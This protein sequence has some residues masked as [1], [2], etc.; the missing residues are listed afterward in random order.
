MDLW[1]NDVELRFFNE[2]L[3]SFAAPEKLFYKLGKEYYAYV[4]KNVGGDGDTVQSRNALIGNF[5]EKWCKTLFEPIASKLGL[6]ALNDVVCEEIAL[7]SNSRADLAFCSTDD[8]KQ[9]P[10]NIK[11]I[12]EIKMSI[13]SNYKYTKK[14][15][16]TVIG[17]YNSHSGTP[18][19]LRSDSMLKAIG[20]A[21]NIRTIDTKSNRIPIVVLGCSPITVN[22][23]HKADAL[24]TAGV[25]QGFWSLNPYPTTSTF[26]E[27]TEKEGFI[28]IQSVEEL[29]KRCEQLLLSDLN[30]FSTMIAKTRLGEIIGIA[31]AEENEIKKAEKFL[32]LIKG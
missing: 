30:Y 13:V 5:T 14:E 8:T 3:K 23:I 11:I 29:Y 28:T 18:S 22:Y 20:K 15:G 26:I 19:L 16:V 4:P 7:P 12:F 1:N 2:A 25:L 27:K 32:E 24:K 21:I 6:Y 10:E 9:I 17:D 31:N